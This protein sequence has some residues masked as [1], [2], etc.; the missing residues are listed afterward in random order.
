MRDEIV[1]KEQRREW[2]VVAVIIFFALITLFDYILIWPSMFLYVILEKIFIPS[3]I[4]NDDLFLFI[5]RNFYQLITV[6]LVYLIVVRIY[7]NSFYK[8]LKINNLSLKTIIKY[9]LLTIVVYVAIGVSALGIKYL[10]YQTFFKIL[11]SRRL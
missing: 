6:L 5:A 1:N 3:G 11:Y 7:R 9:A 10:L 4:Y 2:G 8:S